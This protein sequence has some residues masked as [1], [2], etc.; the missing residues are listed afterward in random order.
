[1]F[2]FLKPFHMKLFKDLLFGIHRLW[3]GDHHVLH[4]CEDS[5]HGGLDPLLHH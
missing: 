4:P 2:A 3:L 5:G 1:M